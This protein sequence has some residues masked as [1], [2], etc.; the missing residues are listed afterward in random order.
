MS[1]Q[2]SFST[3]ISSRK[4]ICVRLLMAAI[5]AVFIFQSTGCTTS[6]CLDW[7]HLL[8]EPL[9]EFR[10]K[11]WAQRAYNSRY[12]NC[13][14]KYGDHFRQGFIEGYSAICSGQDGY[15]PALPPENYWGQEYQC[16]QGSKCVNAWFEGYPAGAEAA[17]ADGAGQFHNV[18]ISKM[19]NTSVTQDNANHILPDDVPVKAP[20]E[21]KPQRP[22]EVPITWN[23]NDSVGSTT[24]K[25]PA[26]KMLDP[27]VIAPRHFKKK[28]NSQPQSASPVQ[29][30]TWNY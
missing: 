17:Q 1:S 29:P 15:V 19:A 27:M 20:A 24:A 23:S 7:D 3:N 5:A 6:G 25:G 26:P 16:A 8:D 28:P 30:A 21:V 18:Y 22:A 14:R 10:Q 11:T 12:A 13:D 9:A 4:N 2:T